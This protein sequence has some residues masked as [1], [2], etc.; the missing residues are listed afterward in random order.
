MTV[1]ERIGEE[2]MEEE[3]TGLST[4]DL[5]EIRTFEG[6]YWRTSLAQFTFS[7]FILRIFEPAFFGTGIVFLMLGCTLLVIS[8]LRRRNSFDTL[9]HSKPFVTS[10]GCVAITGLVAMIAYVT[11][12]SLVWALR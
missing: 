5:V 6:A 4:A 8:F 11:L 12:L 2:Q 1:E 9:D 7:L 3:R 10:G